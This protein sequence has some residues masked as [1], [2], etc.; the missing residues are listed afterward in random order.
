MQ[1]IVHIGNKSFAV[2][3]D[4][5]VLRTD[6]SERAEAAE[7]A[8]EFDTHHG[9]IFTSRTG[10]LVG[11][12]T[13]KIEK[14]LICGAAYLAQTAGASEDIVFIEPIDN[15]SSWLCAIRNG[16]PLQNFDLVVPNEDVDGLLAELSVKPIRI[17]GP[18]SLVEVA[19]EVE[20]LS[21]EDGEFPE[22][23]YI[24]QI[25]GIP[26]P[27]LITGI[28]GTFVVVS[29]L[30]YWA[31]ESHQEQISSELMRINIQRADKER[32][33]QVRQKELEEVTAKLNEELFN[34]VTKVQDY[35]Q[36]VSN[37]LSVIEEVPM[38]IAAWKLATVH[39]EYKFCEAVYSR[40]KISTI[41]DFVAAEKPRGFLMDGNQ[42]E[43]ATIKTVFALQPRSLDATSLP[44]KD[45]VEHFV[46]RFQQMELAGL[47]FQITKAEQKKKMSTPQNGVPPFEVK[48]DWM[49]GTYTLN[50]T[51][52]FEIRDSAAYLDFTNMS[53]AKLDIDFSS[54][55]WSIGGSYAIR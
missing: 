21:W 46:S 16:A 17:Y 55:K 3:L 34:S 18:Q 41:D 6:A 47:N 15:S 12:Y 5:Q 51:R 43:K 13:G 33:E 40:Q 8:K 10:T 38:S 14:K 9:I 32:L 24:E 29:L 54:N 49:L 19:E 4:W 2:G 26:K 31:Y 25:R 27:L 36:V 20:L 52:I 50:G 11:I 7:I 53:A 28:I 37:W 23:P 22:F 1:T 45:F 44:N 30:G 48:S 39:C 35:G 42:M